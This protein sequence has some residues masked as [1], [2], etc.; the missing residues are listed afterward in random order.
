[1]G[2]L[3]KD[4]IG[5]EIDADTV[6]GHVSP[7]TLADPITTLRLAVAFLELVDAVAADRDQDL[8]FRG[9][10]VVDKCTAVFA[11]VNLPDA[12]RQCAV[13]ALRYLGS[14]ARAPRGIHARAS[15]VREARAKLPRGYKALAFVGGTRRL[16]DA[17]TRAD[18]YPAATLSI[19]AT[20]IRVGGKEPTVTLE[21][22]VEERTFTLRVAKDR[23][24]ELAK[25]LYAQVDIEAMVYRADDGLIESGHLVDFMPLEEGDPI[26]AWSAFVRDGF[27][28]STH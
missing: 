17:S 18:G 15:A 19:R 1:V 22:A 21:S 7:E 6:E 9:L 28:G 24:K 20:P 13:E 3:P 11:H 10:Q 4:A 8:V 12:G 26:E 16:L 23:A 5:I 27:R 14:A 2:R 25:H